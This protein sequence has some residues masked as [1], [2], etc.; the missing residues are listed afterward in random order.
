MAARKTTKVHG[1][2]V[3]DMKS[4]PFSYNFLSNYTHR[5]SQTFVRVPRRLRTWSRFA[6][7]VFIIFG[8]TICF[9]PWTQTVTLQGKLSAYSPA[10]R[11]Q[12]IHS[13]INGS[14]KIWHVNEGDNV[15][16]GDLVL[17]LEDINPQFMA[18]DLL[19]RLD[20]SREALEQ[21]RQAAMERAEIFADRINEMTAL[22]YAAKSSAEARVSEADNKTLVTEQRVTP[23]KGAEEITA[24]NL[25]R[26]YALAA[27]GLISQRELELAI[28]A[29]TV[30]EAEVKAARAAFS[31]A[32][33]A[34]RALVHNREQINAE[35]LQRLLET[36]SNRASALSD[37]AIA[38]K[39]LAEL[40][41]TRSNAIQRR[42][43]SRV[44][45]PLDGTV[46]RVTPIG[47][48]EIVHPGDLLITIVPNGAMPAVEM[49][50]D[51][52]D[53]PLLSP[54]RPVRL[55]FQGLPAIPLPAWP[56]FMAGSF[57]GRIQVVDQTTSENG[58]F[59]LWVAPDINR[60]KW[61]SQTHVRQG[62][63]VMGWVILNRVP[64]W[65]ELWRRFNLFPADY[66]TGTKNLKDAFFLKLGI[67]G[68]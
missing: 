43:A 57:E 49:W 45:A 47:H 10:E 1:L 19:N 30:T 54:N 14:I 7:I 38:S 12:E 25:E 51:S 5:K 56:E 66:E 67:P 20:Q 9:V 60:R 63:K 48:G 22:A 40:A 6:L 44:V 58:R 16:K 50:A 68:K 18:P 46:V 55:L 32:Q 15:K 59:R 8:A 34:Q 52:I 42:N 61:P 4:G 53:A 31:E 13:Q 27:E 36:K 17:E 65:Y 24:L 23:A 21:Q 33:E 35:L 11:P 28:Q 37:T 64:L 41:L 39:E 29:A 26:S 2:V 62:T 3:S